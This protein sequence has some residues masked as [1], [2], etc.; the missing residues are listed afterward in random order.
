MA[1]VLDHGQVVGNEEIGQAE[2]ALQV[3]HQV[4]DLRLNGDIEGRNRFVGDDE[5]RRER[6]RARDPD[7]LALA[8]GELVRVMGHVRFAQ[9]HALEQ[10]RH[11][12]GSVLGRAEAVD[13]QGFAHDAA[14]GHAGIKRGE[15]VLKN[16]LHLRAMTPQL[17]FAEMGDVVPV[18][19]DASG[20]RLDEAQRRP[21]YG[22]FAA[23]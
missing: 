18:E 3:H 4:E 6:E 2:L 22:R 8:A 21:A 11:P 1:Y 14:H 10:L 16:D 17:L 12:R 13:A 20:G 9:P 7:T 19:L 23:A 15:R 5:L